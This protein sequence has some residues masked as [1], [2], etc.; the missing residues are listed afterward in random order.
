MSRS[1]HQRVQQV[2]A[3]ARRML[4]QYGLA[5]FGAALAAIVVGLGLLD[6]FLRP[7]DSLSRWILSLAAVA[8]SIMALAKLTWPAA[9]FVQSLVA[10]ARRIERRFPELGE[11]LSSAIAFLAQDEN[12]ITAGSPDLRR[13]VIAEADALSSGLD[14]REALD[15]RPLRR[16]AL[17]AGLMLA[18]AA[19]LALLSP[20]AAGLAVVRLAQPWRE[21]PWPRRHELAFD[22]PPERLAKGDDWELVL[23]DRRGSLP[24][25]TRLELRYEHRG[26]WRTETREL[27]PVGDRMVFHQANVTHG[28]QYRAH[29]GDDDTMPWFDLAVVEPPKIVDLRVIVD[30]PAYTGQPRQSAGRVVTALVGSQLQ[31]VGKLDAPVQSGAIQSETKDFVLPALELFAGGLQ[32]RVPAGGVAWPVER[33]GTFSLG[34][35]DPHGMTFGRDTRI[36]L[37]AVQDA[38]PS[39]A[40][41]SPADHSFVTARA[42]VRI[43]GAVKD[44]LAVRDV[45]LRY[46]RPGKSDEEQLVEIYAGP[47]AAPAT[48]EV[49]GQGD[50]RT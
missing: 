20:S 4:W 2:Q 32:F 18:F 9:R 36:E 7:H 21:L 1:L 6:Y 49:A 33:S 50:Y 40:W 19:G 44:D 38:A 23:V 31:I 14:F 28:F 43:K 26:V 46:L 48:N 45:Q 15:V 30:P 42:I 25:D 8:L 34:L 11:R 16:A 10:T 41:E 22:K 24:D 37:H 17:T 29:G 13:A 3:Q 35:T 27:K 5:R 12:A 39:I 47:A